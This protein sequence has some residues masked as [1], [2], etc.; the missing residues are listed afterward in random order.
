MRKKVSVIVPVYNAEAFLDRCIQSLLCQTY[1]NIEM[2]L[3]DDG[4][5]D[6]SGMMCDVFAAENERIRALHI[7]EQGVS[8]ARNIGI[9]EADGDYITFVDADDCP[10]PDMVEYLA[11]NLEGTGSD[12]SGCSYRV[13]Y[14]DAEAG[15]IRKSKGGKDSSVEILENK[16][17]IEKGILKS[18]T[19]CWS[20]L[21]R[22]ESIKNYYF[23]TDLTIGED[24]IFL[25]DL[26]RSG[27]KFCRSDYKGYGYFINN[28]GAMMGSFKDGYMDQITCWQKALKVIT[29]ETPEYKDKAAA[30]LLTAVMLAAGKLAMLPG[31]ERREKKEYIERCTELVRKYSSCKKVFHQLDK[32]YRIKISLY[33]CFPYLYMKLYHS[34]KA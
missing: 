33:R 7:E 28:T 15:D 4:S 9:D 29:E 6:K 26:A 3:V 19:R 1:P 20:K 16:A 31:K 8:A 14:N 23:D 30:I 25:L 10:A 18:D 5:A 13:F 12:V 11:D 22:K 21:Y 32:G 17:F 2:I 27:K 24:M 34:L